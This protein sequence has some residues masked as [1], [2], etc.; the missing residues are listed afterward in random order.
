MI[1]ISYKRHFQQYEL[2]TAGS[3]LVMNVFKGCTLS[4]GKHHPGDENPVLNPKGFVLFLHL[5]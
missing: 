3:I 2:S 4:V 5:L 1:G